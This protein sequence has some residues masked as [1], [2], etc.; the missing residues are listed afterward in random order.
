MSAKEHII[1]DMSHFVSSLDVS[2][3]DLFGIDEESI[4]SDRQDVCV[5]I[6]RTVRRKGDPMSNEDICAM[7]MK[8]SAFVD[9]LVDSQNTLY[10]LMTIRMDDIDKKISLVSFG[11]GLNSTMKKNVITDSIKGTA[12]Y[13]RTV[14]KHVPALVIYGLWRA[15]KKDEPYPAQFD[16]TMDGSQMQPG[17]DYDLTYAEREGISRCYLSRALYLYTSLVHTRHLRRID[18]TAEEAF[19]PSG[20]RNAGTISITPRWRKS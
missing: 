7:L 12:T 2:T 15:Y 8:V 6:T 13:T 19:I 14:M 9:R 4:H 10:R 18:H 11:V 5:D 3:E 1:G 20:T 16:Y 17:R